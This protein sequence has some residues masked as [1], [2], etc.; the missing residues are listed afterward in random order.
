MKR[1]EFEHCIK[2]NE[3]IETGDKDKGLAS[4][5][6]IL[7][8]H[9]EQFWKEVKLEEKY[10]SLYIEGHYEIIKELATAIFALD[11]WKAVNHECLFA[12]LQEKKQE[13]ELDWN[14]LFEL[15]DIR[16]AIDYRGIKVNPKIWKQNKLKIEITINTLKEYVKKRL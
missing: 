6:L 11:G 4:E 8:E 10:P 13:L 2:E 12:Y 7:A 14:Y 15:K 3:L 1:K 9:R 5:I 16:N